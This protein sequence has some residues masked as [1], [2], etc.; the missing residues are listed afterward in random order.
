[1]SISGSHIIIHEDCRE[2]QVALSSRIPWG[3]EVTTTIDNPLRCCRRTSRGSNTT[4]Y[5][6]CPPMLSTPGQPQVPQGASCARLTNLSPSV[7]TS[8]PHDERTFASAFP[9]SPDTR[10]KHSQ[11]P[12]R[13]PHLRMS[14]WSQRRQQQNSNAPWSAEQPNRGSSDTHPCGTHRP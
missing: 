13:E 8:G 3:Q 10:D 14:R 5:H 2:D 4:E 6:Y 7:P 1:M 11:P 9:H 12:Q